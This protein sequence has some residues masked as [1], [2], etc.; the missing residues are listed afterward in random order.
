MGSRE[1]KS[2]KGQKYEDLSIFH[3]VMRQPRT[4]PRIEHKIKI[5]EKKQPD[6]KRLITLGYRTMQEFQEHL[7]SDME[8][9]PLFFASSRCPSIDRSEGLF[10][11]TFWKMGPDHPDLETDKKNCPKS[12]VKIP[13]FEFYSESLCRSL[14]DWELTMHFCFGKLDKQKI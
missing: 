11:Q 1:R 8:S 12:P 3:N 14:I 10:R 7:R 5:V 6:K 9:S 13:I 2:C 4:Q